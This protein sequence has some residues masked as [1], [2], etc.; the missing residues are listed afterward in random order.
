M[1]GRVTELDLSGTIL[2]EKVILPGSVSSLLAALVEDGVAS[3][4]V[5]EMVDEV[6]V[7]SGTTVAPEGMLDSNGPVSESSDV[8]VEA[9]RR[10]VNANEVEV[11]SVVLAVVKGAAVAVAVAN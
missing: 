3:G 5:V 8:V 11:V 4:M 7:A 9:R 2:V 6:D 10:E 1:V